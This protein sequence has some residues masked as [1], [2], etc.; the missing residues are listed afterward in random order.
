MNSK[1]TTSN[2]RKN[3]IWLG[4]IRVFSIVPILFFW[5]LAFD[6][7]ELTGEKKQWK[8]TTGSP[9]YWPPSRIYKSKLETPSTNTI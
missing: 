5:L 3:N 8:N 1:E 9:L 4:C 6:S 2:S 7:I